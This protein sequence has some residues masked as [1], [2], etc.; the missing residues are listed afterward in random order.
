MLTPA[1]TAV[2]VGE[3]EIK[4]TP[5]SW[6]QNFELDVKVKWEKSGKRKTEGWTRKVFRIPLC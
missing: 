1:L 3:K 4:L 6:Q 5:A 2:L